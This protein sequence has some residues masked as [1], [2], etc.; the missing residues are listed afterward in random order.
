MIYICVCGSESGLLYDF[1]LPSCEHRHTDTRIHR[2]TN[3]QTHKY[4]DTQTHKCT[5]IQTHRHTDAHGWMDG[6]IGNKSNTV[7]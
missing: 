5:D 7:N 4:R 1:I 3:I 6:L 2:H